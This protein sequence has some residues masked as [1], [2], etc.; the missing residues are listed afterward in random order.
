MVQVHFGLPLEL[1]DRSNNAFAIRP[2]KCELA[3]IERIDRAFEVQR[4]IGTRIQQRL[5][6]QQQCLDDR[7]LAA[8]ITTEQHGERCQLQFGLLMA[9]EVVKFDRSQ[10]GT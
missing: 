3:Q 4:H 1:Q 7:A 9:L 2:C 10:L 6:Q 5:L 8:V